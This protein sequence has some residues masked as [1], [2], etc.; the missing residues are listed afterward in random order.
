MKFSS[1][2]I[3]VFIISFALI[4]SSVAFSTT[5][6]I[7]EPQPVCV[8]TGTVDESGQPN[9]KCTLVDSGLPICSDGLKFGTKCQMAAGDTNFIDCTPNG[10]AL[11]W[12]CTALEDQ[13]AAG[14]DNSISI[15]NFGVTPGDAGSPTQFHFEEVLAAIG[16]F[17]LKNIIYIN[18]GDGTA[19]GS[20]DNLQKPAAA[21]KTHIYEQPGTYTLSV[22]AYVQ[23]GPDEY[24]D[25]DSVTIE[26]VANSTTPAERVTA[27]A[28]PAAVVNEALGIN[29]AENP[30][31]TPTDQAATSQSPTP[32]QVQSAGPVQTVVTAVTA[33][34]RSIRNF[35]GF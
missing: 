23:D 4:F 34:F 20:K 2:R 16:P 19:F 32:A 18:Y 9:L 27:S 33:V 21:P 10:G 7:A 29:V 31:A 35:F 30:S 12:E 26:I 24:Y 15:P 14:E 1:K 5:P 6:A 13:D 25:A 28:A 11:P 3:R 17:A 8:D 22:F